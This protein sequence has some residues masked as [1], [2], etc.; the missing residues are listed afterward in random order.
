MSGIAFPPRNFSAVGGNPKRAIGFAAFNE[1]SASKTRG[2]VQEIPRKTGPH[3]K[4]GHPAA[5][6][7]DARCVVRRRQR[8]SCETGLRVEILHEPA[9]HLDRQGLETR[10]RP[11]GDAECRRLQRGGERVDLARATPASATGLP[12]TRARSAARNP[13]IEASSAESF[14][15]RPLSSRPA[16]ALAYL[17]RRPPSQNIR[18]SAPAAAGGASARVR[19]SGALRE[20][21]LPLGLLRRE[22]RHRRASALRPASSASCQ[23]RA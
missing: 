19:K 18:R 2:H 20:D 11:D 4:S 12:L 10:R 17:L 14:E 16:S 23:F 13:G 22:E 9:K 7:Q 21:R 15:F 1:A 5:N 6:L 8:Q 3:G